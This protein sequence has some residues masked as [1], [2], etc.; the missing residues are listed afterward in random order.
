MTKQNT[1]PNSGEFPEDDFGE[2]LA[3]DDFPTQEELDDAAPFYFAL[4]SYVKQLKDARKKAG[5]KLADVAT[6][7]EMAVESLSRLE[8]GAATNPTWKTLGMYA[9]AVGC[10]PFLIA[11]PLLANVPTL[12]D[13]GRVMQATNAVSVPVFIPTAASSWVVYPSAGPSGVPVTVYSGMES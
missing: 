6:R 1:I 13:S 10:R 7:S 8:T 9:K 12:G 3:P 11:I 5:M 4:R 2:E